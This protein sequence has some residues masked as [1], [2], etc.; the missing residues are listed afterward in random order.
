MICFVLVVAVV[1]IV[2]EFQ[3]QFVRVA[4]DGLEARIHFA[5]RRDIGAFAQFFHHREHGLG[6]LVEQLEMFLETAAVQVCRENQDAL[7]DFL[8]GLGNLVER[9]SE[10]LDVLA[11]ER[12]DESFAKLLGQ[13]LGD[14]FIFPAAVD[15]FVQALRR[16]VMLEFTQ[17]ID[18]MVDAA[19]GLLRAFFEQVV[20]LFVVSEE[21]ADREHKLA[22]ALHRA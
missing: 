21:L 1:K 19:V 9:G 6:G 11:F 7:P 20:E 4:F 16:I 10:G 2:E 17:Q 5:G 13:L 3:L 18:E 14:P 22:I 8:N 12:S 15:E